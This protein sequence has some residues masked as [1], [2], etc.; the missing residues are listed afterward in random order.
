M[1]TT[2]AVR[3]T[4]RTSMPLM[5]AGG[6]YAWFKEWLGGLPVMTPRRSEAFETDDGPEALDLL[7]R[8]HAVHWFVVLELA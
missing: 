8:L 2:S 3:Y 5:Y 7:A 4:L 6:S 1:T